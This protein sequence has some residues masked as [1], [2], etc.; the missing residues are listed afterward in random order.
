MP[1]EDPERLALLVADPPSGQRSWTYPIWQEIQRHA[2]R[3]DGAFAW[4]RFDAQ[5]NLT[6]GGETQF[7]NG[8][9]AS[10][11]VTRGLWY[12]V[13]VGNNL[14]ALGITATQLTRAFAAGGSMW[15]MPTTKEFG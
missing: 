4:T 11:E 7:A 12:L 5:F 9:W 8:V 2:D 14:S 3:F 13:M 15:W 6:Q 10:G 1:V